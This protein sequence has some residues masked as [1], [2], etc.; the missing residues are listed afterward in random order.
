[1]AAVSTFLMFQ[2]EAEEAVNF[3]TSIIENS[4]IESLQKYGKEGPGKEG[5]VFRAV[6][7]LNGV[8]YM[9]IDS[10]AVHDFTFTPSLSIFVSCE[11]EAEINLLWEKLSNGGE[12]LMAIGDHG[13]SKRFGW[14]ND[15]FGVSWQVNLP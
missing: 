10:P 15:R 13:F 3:Y 2:G 8:K 7:T 11:S 12:E 4:S 9:A 14:V 5:S 1:M 6:F